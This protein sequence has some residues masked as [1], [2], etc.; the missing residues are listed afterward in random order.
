MS[1]KKV[2]HYIGHDQEMFH[3]AMRAVPEDQIPNLYLL[4]KAGFD[5]LVLAS[6]L[7]RAE[8]FHEILVNHHSKVLF[9]YVMFKKQIYYVFFV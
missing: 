2:L 8:I 7:G 4:N 9:I 1:T 6:R 3:Y 5:P